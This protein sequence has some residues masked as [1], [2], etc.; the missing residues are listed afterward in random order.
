[1][2]VCQRIEKMLALYWKLCDRKRDAGTVQVTLSKFFYKE[3][4]HFGFV[5]FSCFKLQCPNFVILWIYKFLYT[6]KINSRTNFKVLRKHFKVM[7]K[8]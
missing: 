8:L 3:I 2:V 5:C 1:M 4:K 6:F 7:E